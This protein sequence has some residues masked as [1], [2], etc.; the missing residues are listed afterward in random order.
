MPLR[1]SLSSQ[2]AHLP[3][4]GGDDPRPSL[5]DHAPGG[6]GHDDCGR[7][8]GASGSDAGEADRRGGGQEGRRITLLLGS[9]A[10]SYGQGD[11]LR[12]T[13]TVKYTSLSPSMIL[14]MI[15]FHITIPSPYAD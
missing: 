2:G 14:T 1:L 8:A 15:G 11:I 3:A 12:K 9:S 4:R 13:F 10:A 5:Q 6:P 7:R